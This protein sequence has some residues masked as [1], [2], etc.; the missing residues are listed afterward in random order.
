LVSSSQ[1]KINLNQ[2]IGLSDAAIVGTVTGVK[3]EIRNFAP[4]PGEQ[5][6]Y[7]VATVRV[8][9]YLYNA[10]GLTDKQL[11]ISLVGGRTD[12]QSTGV[13]M[14][15]PVVGSQYVLFVKKAATADEY[16]IP[17]GPQG[18]FELVDQQIGKGKDQSWLAE[19]VFGHPFNLT[20]LRGA[21]Q[22]AKPEPLPG[23]AQ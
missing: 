2:L 18:L 19:N 3:T 22:N 15:L 21:L 20:A 6:V 1:V 11:T 10:A 16:T 9:E 4:L 8:D 17:A 12:S 7:T 23:T 5:A 13:E 14:T